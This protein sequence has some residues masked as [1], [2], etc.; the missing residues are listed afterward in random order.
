MAF[1]FKQL[2]VE[3]DLAKTH[4]IVYGE[5]GTGKTTFAAAMKDKDGKPPFFI[6]TE[7]G[8]GTLRPWGQM[9]TSWEGFLKLQ[10]ILL[11]EKRAEFL[12]RFG[13]LVFDVIGDLDEFAVKAVLDKHKVQSLSDLPH[14]KGW[15]AHEQ[16]FKEGFEPFLKFMPCIFLAHVEEKEVLWQGE[17]VNVQK[18][19][20]AKRIGYYLNGKCDFIMYMQPPNSK[21]EHREIAMIPELGRWGK[22]RYPHMNRAFRNHKNDPG[23]T[24]AEM[25]THF[26]APPPDELTPAQMEDDPRPDVKETEAAKEVSA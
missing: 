3:T 22:A 9:I 20:F 19:R 1:E 5:P 12:S 25:M 6:M 11:H 15:T 2:D 13:S 16:F 7:K 8:N 17:K 10:G 14:G 24:W 4:R 26:Q 23:R 18:P 21:K